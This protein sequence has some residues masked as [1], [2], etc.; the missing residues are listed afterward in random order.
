MIETYT[1]RASDVRVDMSIRGR[2]PT[3]DASRVVTYPAIGQQRVN[4]A[5]SYKDIRLV[6][7]VQGKGEQ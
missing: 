5:T 3:I 4:F 7:Y 6:V 1:E 2:P